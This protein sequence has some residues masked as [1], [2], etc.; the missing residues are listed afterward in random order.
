MKK[1]YNWGC[2]SVGRALDLHSRGLGFNSPQLHIFIFDLTFFFEC[3]LKFLS[4][5][6]KND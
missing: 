6:L 3:L 1:S 5:S 4:Y 2:S